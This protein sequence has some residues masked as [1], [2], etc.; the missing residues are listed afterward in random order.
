MPTSADPRRTLLDPWVGLSR[1]GTNN[2]NSTARA[3]SSARG[4]SRHLTKGDG[5]RLRRKDGGSRV[6]DLEKARILDNYEASVARTLNNRPGRPGSHSPAMDNWAMALG[7][8]IEHSKAAERARRKLEHEEAGQSMGRGAWAPVVPPTTAPNLSSSSNRRVK[9]GC[10]TF[11]GPAGG[12]RGPVV[13]EVAALGG[14]LSELQGR[15]SSVEGGAARNSNH[16][17]VPT[18]ISSATRVGGRGDGGARMLERT[19]PLAG[20]GDEHGESG[21]MHVAS[22][23][24]IYGIPQAFITNA[25]EVRKSSIPHAVLEIKKNPCQ[26]V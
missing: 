17:I 8:D 20:V 15:L 21:S 16:T 26:V 23:A 2:N 6:R 9:R 19:A 7:V 10:D 5:L 3:R 4:H 25:E 24:D 22:F 12:R 11:H 1:G 13:P 18:P 14:F